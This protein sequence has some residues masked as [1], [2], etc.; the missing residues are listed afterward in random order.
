MPTEAALGIAVRRLRAAVWFLL[1]I[2]ACATFA[3]AWIVT[4]SG[5]SALA[6]V[7]NSLF[8]VL[9]V[10]SLVTAAAIHFRHKWSVATVWGAALVFAFWYIFRN[11]SV[12]GALMAVVVAYLGASETVKQLRVAPNQAPHPTPTAAEAPASGVG[13]RRR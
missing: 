9:G 4:T 5:A 3:T 6:S 13:E 2:G 1:F 7:R 12:F 10:V 8:L 11:Q